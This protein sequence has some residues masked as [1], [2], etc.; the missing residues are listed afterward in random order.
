MTDSPTFKS[1]WDAWLVALF[2]LSSL[3][4][5]GITAWVAL[6]EPGLSAVARGL[7]LASGL[8]TPL[9][10]GWL[11]C[12][13]DY[14]VQAEQLVV[15]SGP[16]QWR[17]PLREIEGVRPSR[18]LLSGPAGSLDRLA[19]ARRGKHDLLISPR[20]RSGFFAALLARAHHLAPEGE[21]R[22]RRRSSSER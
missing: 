11:M 17:V 2:G 20:D 7:L 13:T 12:S 22:L 18:S 5:V 14:T 21:S 9:L 10:L 16:F 4:S 8:L 19:I 6:A 15:R 3:I 1:A